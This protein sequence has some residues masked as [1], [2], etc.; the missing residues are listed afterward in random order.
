MLLT[1]LI[2]IIK[3]R[4]SRMNQNGWENDFQSYFYFTPLFY[5]LIRYARCT[6][7]LTLECTFHADFQVLL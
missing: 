6:A 2:H 3:R 4:Q 1:A 7:L 5:P